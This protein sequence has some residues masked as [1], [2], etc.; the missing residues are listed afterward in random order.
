M[1]HSVPPSGLTAL[2]RGFAL[3]AFGA[4]LATPAF[5]ETVY[6]WKD[7]QGIT[8]Y[9]S[10]PPPE[11]SARQLDLKPPPPPRDPALDRQSL[12]QRVETANRQSAE[13]KDRESKAAAREQEAA[14]RVQ[15][16][17][18]ARQQL[19]VLKAGV[20]VYGRGSDGKRAYLDEAERRAALESAEAEFR[21]ACSGVDDTT[22]RAATR[23]ANRDMRSAILCADARERVAQLT[24]SGTRASSEDIRRA[25]AAMEKQCGR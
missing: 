13:Q 16:C 25:Q 11:G 4:S 14:A 15:R 21:E 1:F 7:A 18:L 23:E 9:S 10:S 19:G 24:R 8:H 12:Q 6:R 17:G 2:V 22:M 5:A 20:P 3:L